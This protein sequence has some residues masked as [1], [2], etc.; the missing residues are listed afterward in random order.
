MTPPPLVI[1][2]I[3]AGIIA[4]LTFRH[5]A[6]FVLSIPG[7]VPPPSF[8]LKPAPSLTVPAIALVALWGGLWGAILA[9]LLARFRRERRYW[10]MAFLYGAVL[11]TLPSVT[12]VLVAH[13]Q[14]AM[15][16]LWLELI[17]GLI[18]NGVWGVGTALI[19]VVL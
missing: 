16:V 1:R 4:A 19:L 9:L 3:L 5:A 7:L 2:G 10:H 11:L 13:E 18:V 8:S 15:S 12:I 17:V 6:L 14:S